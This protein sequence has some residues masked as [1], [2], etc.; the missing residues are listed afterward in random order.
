MSADTLPRLAVAPCQPVVMYY[1]L[2]TVHVVLSAMGVQKGGV[3]ICIGS[4]K[5]LLIILACYAQL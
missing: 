1:I 3:P 2:Y 5:Q 4:I